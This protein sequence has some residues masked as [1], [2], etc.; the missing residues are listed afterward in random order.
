MLLS[1]GCDSSETTRADKGQA[2][3]FAC[4]LFVIKPWR[5]EEEMRDVL[6][7]LVDPVDFPLLPV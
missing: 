2:G 5:A 1:G 7:S 3:M 4:L 6:S